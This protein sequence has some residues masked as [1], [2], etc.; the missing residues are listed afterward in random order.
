MLS[1]KDKRVHCKL[2]SLWGGCR[3]QRQELININAWT[4]EVSSQNGVEYKRLKPKRLWRKALAPLKTSVNPFVWSVRSNPILQVK[5]ADP[6]NQISWIKTPYPINRPSVKRR[7]D[8]QWAKEKDGKTEE[9]PVSETTCFRTL[10]AKADN[11]SIK[12]EARTD[13]DWASR[14]PKE[15]SLH[16]TA[17]SAKGR[18]HELSPRTAGSATFPWRAPLSKIPGH[19]PKFQIPSQW[20]NSEVNRSH[21]QSG[22]GASG[23]DSGN[24]GTVLIHLGRGCSGASQGDEQEVGRKKW[25]NCHRLM[26]LWALRRKWKKTPRRCPGHRAQ[27]RL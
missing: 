4:S 3:G 5:K 1:K 17:L 14:F 21:S 15:Q 8:L 20:G 23:D 22:W 26:D 18:Q 24:L 12:N 27:S 9:E 16:D 11:T 10:L 2:Q 13:I 19:H 7:S 6:K 25:I